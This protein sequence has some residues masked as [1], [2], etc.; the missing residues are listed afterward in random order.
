MRDEEYYIINQ[1]DCGLLS[2]I[3]GYELSFTQKLDEAIT[4]RNKEYARAVARML[5]DY[6]DEYDVMLIH[7]VSEEF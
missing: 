6:Y 1:S 2:R 3:D 4:F 5:V 7:T